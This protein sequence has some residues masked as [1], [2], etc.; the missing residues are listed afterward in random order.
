MFLAFCVTVLTGCFPKQK[1]PASDNKVVQIGED[2][3]GKSTVIQIGEYLTGKSTTDS[4]AESP[5]TSAPYSS[6]SASYTSAIVPKSL[7]KRER[8]CHYE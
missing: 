1:P 5:E 7:P 2:L 3:T 8:D 6:Q 4:G